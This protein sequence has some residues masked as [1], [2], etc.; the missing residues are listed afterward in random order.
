MLCAKVGSCHLSVFLFVRLFGILKVHMRPLLKKHKLVTLLFFVGVLL[1]LNLNSV[2][3]RGMFSSFLAP[4]Q[5]FLWEA[6]RTTNIVLEGTCAGFGLESRVMELEA[7]NFFLSQELL[8][9]KEVEKE[10]DRLRQ[11][12]DG[13]LREEFDL[14]FTKIIG[15]EVDRDVLFLNKGAQDGVKQGM[16]VITQSRV[17]VGSIGEVFKHTSKVFLFSLKDRSSDVKL[18][19]KEVIGV[20]K[21]Q[22]RFQA[23]L[24]FIPKEEELLKGDALVTSALGGVFPDNFLVGEVKSVEKSDLTAFQGGKVELFFHPRQE[25]SLF[26][27][28]NYQ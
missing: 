3:I 26:V 20:L 10:N 13:I 15:K 5:S 22:G 9:L 2:T 8:L 27:L 19:G 25:N 24:G 16:P 11:S 23:F 1:L 18:Q 17:A 7:K 4:L 12:L 28:T 21:G 14:L 6:G